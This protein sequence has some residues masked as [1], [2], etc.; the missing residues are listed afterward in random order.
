MLAFLAAGFLTDDLALL[1]DALALLD[2]DLALLVDACVVVRFFLVTTCLRTCLAGGFQPT[3]LSA[4][5]LAGMA[6]G[7]SA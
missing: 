1:D 7:P 3:A 5:N 4:R 6:I 2:E